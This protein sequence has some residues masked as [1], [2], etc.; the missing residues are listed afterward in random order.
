MKSMTRLSAA[1]FLSYAF[2]ATAQAETWPQFRGSQ[3]LGVSSETNLPAH[4]TPDSGLQWTVD[5]PGHANS[6]PA[7]TAARIDLTTQLEDNSLVVLSIDRT[8]GKII[9]QTNVGKGKLAAKGP[10]N[11]YA[12]RHNAA[13]PSP[14]A[15]D[16]HVWAF[17]GTGLLV[18]VDAHSGAIKW[19][20]DM[21]REYGAYNITFGMGSSPRL[22]GD[23]LYVACMTKGPSY[24]VAFD[25][26]TGQ[27][28]WKASRRLPAADD[29]PDAYST[30]IIY[31]AKTGFELL[32]SGSDH[33]NAYDLSSGKQL[34]VSDGLKIDSPYGRVIASPT[35]ADGVIVATSANPAGAGK[36]RLIAIRTGGNGN[37]S[38]SNRLWEYSQ[39]TPD[40][41]T[42][43]IYKGRLF[44]CAD[45]GVAK[46]FDLRTGELQWTKRLATGPY[47][48]SLVA[49]DRKVYFI[50]IKG[51]C[52]VMAADSRPQ[53]LARNQLPG[54]FYAT[55]AISDGV[56]YLRAYE[57]LYAVRG[58]K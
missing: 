18:C 8:N 2:F 3:G 57:K 1:L 34:W 58:D 42:P 40:S 9:R 13:T 38:E 14:I 51:L 7:V 53:D 26:N 6:S 43:V 56:L 37:I 20:H 48:A 35:A 10:A 33:V 27:E 30:P 49:G 22:W 4:W 41:S 21:V 45:S 28:V 46:C 31:H 55:P 50:N 11:L 32:V 54:T 12:H 17:F 16:D 5:L 23:L 44:A 39:S 36:G 47:H 29:G 15:D 25:K 52:T 24:V 19:K